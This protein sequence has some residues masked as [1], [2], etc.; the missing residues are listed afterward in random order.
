VLVSVLVIV[1]CSVSFEVLRHPNVWSS[2]VS[3]VEPRAYFVGDW[4]IGSLSLRWRSSMN[5]SLV[6]L[7]DV[8]RLGRLWSA[9]MVSGGLRM[10]GRNMVITGG[11]GGGLC[12]S[13]Q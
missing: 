12:G 7:L 4:I 11:R 13:S 6:I 1:S 2:N 8:S 9:R 5:K 10:V 3:N